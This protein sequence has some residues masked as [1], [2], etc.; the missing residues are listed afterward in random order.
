MPYI[1]R[2]LSVLASV[3]KKWTGSSESECGT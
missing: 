1:L 2:H 3:I